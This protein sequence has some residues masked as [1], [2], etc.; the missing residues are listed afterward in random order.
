MNYRIV[1]KESFHIVGIMK[2][3]PIQFNGVNPEISSMWQSLTGEDIVELK[4]LSNVEP[5]GLIS[6]S[7]HFLKGVWRREESLI[8]I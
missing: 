2:R 5:H 7:V 8:T 3:V 6:A 4:Q 1:E